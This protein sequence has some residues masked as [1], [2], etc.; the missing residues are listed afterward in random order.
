MSHSEIPP[1]STAPDSQSSSTG[2]MDTARELLSSEYYLRKWGRMGMRS[3]SETVDEFGLDPKYEAKYQPYFDFLYDH[4]FRVEAEGVDRIPKTGRCL[5]VANHSG[6]IP[7]DGLM[8]KTCIR[9]ESIHRELR[10]LTEDFL[11]HLPFAGAFMNRLGAVRACQENAQRLLK[12]EKL[13]AVFP[14]GVKGIGKLYNERYQLQ[15]FGRGG[16]VRLALRMQAPIVPCAI[17]GAEE[18]MPL[19]MKLEALAKPL[20]LPYIPITPTF[21]L[22]GPAGLVPAPTKWKI[23]FGPALDLSEY[24]AS[25]ED[26]Q[27][28][29][30]RLSERVRNSI[31]TMLDS[32]VASRKSVFFGLP[33]S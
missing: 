18:S 3:R 17:V 6:S 24:P 15:R 13:V 5:L 32:M 19:L 2:L 11:T 14:E 27:V 9:K 12:H 30:A 26:D 10:W 31:Q 20:G 21:P 22:L 33:S 23:Q 25:R 8:L 16:F 1:R 4:Y 7:L 29:V 28:L